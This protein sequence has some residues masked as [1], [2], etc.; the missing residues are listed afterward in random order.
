[1]S[2]DQG[3]WQIKLCTTHQTY[4]EVYDRL[5]RLLP[6]TTLQNRRR[7]L[8]AMKNN[9]SYLPPVAGYQTSV[10]GGPWVGVI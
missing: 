4:L 1:M 6:S 2:D 10:S 8:R 5:Q 3:E 7:T 9:L